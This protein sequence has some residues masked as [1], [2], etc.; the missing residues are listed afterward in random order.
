[1]IDYPPRAQV[2][3]VLPPHRVAGQ[4]IEWLGPC[5]DCLM[6]IARDAFAHREAVLVFFRHEIKPLTQGASEVLRG[7]FGSSA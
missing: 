7:F 3:E 5:D 1:M 6:F 2:F 4:V